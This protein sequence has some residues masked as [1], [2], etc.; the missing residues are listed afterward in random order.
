MHV[1]RDAD[2]K[3][4]F[5]LEDKPGG[6]PASTAGKT[7][8]L[9]LDWFDK[10]VQQY[11]SG[12]KG[13][14]DKDDGGIVHEIDHAIT[15]APTYIVWI[16]EGLADY[17]RDVLG[18]ERGPIGSIPGSKPYFEMGKAKA[19]YQTTAHFLLW[20]E[21]KYAYDGGRGFFGWI[22]RIL[23]RLFR[24]RKKNVRRLYDDLVNDSYTEGSFRNIYGKTLDELV[25]DYE[26]EFST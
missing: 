16:I 4:T 1:G 25:N 3:L 9:N 10:I 8:Y 7:V 13:D 6:A 11:G 20:L 14:R 15:W 19:G 5:I 24:W 22:T 12:D 17:V 18:Y 26:N 2:Q 21:E 23:R